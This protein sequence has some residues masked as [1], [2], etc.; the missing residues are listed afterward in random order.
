MQVVERAIAAVNARD[1]E[2]YLACCTEDIELSTPISAIAG[3]YAGPE[4]IRRFFA[5]VQDAA[6]D[7]RLD[8]E[9]IES[10]RPDRALGFLRNSASGRA[11]GVPINDAIE[12][13]AVYDFAGGRIRRIRIF[14]DR[15][16]A[17]EAAA[18]RE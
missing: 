10:L 1:V 16:E 15:Q 9:R 3:V 8:I 2:G 17:L 12:T 4:G 5:E 11:S 18:L 13:T 14:L 7:F 6:T